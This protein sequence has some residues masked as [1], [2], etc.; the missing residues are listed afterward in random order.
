ML[1][2]TN[3]DYHFVRCRVTHI[4]YTKRTIDD[5]LHAFH[6]TIDFA[7]DPMEWRIHAVDYMTIMRDVPPYSGMLDAALTADGKPKLLGLPITRVYGDDKST[8]ISRQPLERV[9]D[10]DAV[11]TLAIYEQRSKDLTYEPRR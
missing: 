1:D 6:R 10:R 9:R 5:F 2:R 7:R 8:L 4:L 3:L 11:P